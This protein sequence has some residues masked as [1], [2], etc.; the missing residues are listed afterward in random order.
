LQK[1]GGKEA[2]GR[3]WGGPA[4]S[5]SWHAVAPVG[6]EH[7]CL[8]CSPQSRV[9]VASLKAAPEFPPCPLGAGRPVALPAERPKAGTLPS[10]QPLSR[11]WA[12][13]VSENPECA[14]QWRREY[15]PLA[16]VG[17][18][19][20]GGTHLGPCMVVCGLMALCAMV[21]GSGQTRGW[22]PGSW[23]RPRAITS[24]DDF[25]ASPYPG[26]CS[27]QVCISAGCF[28]DELDFLLPRGMDSHAE[29]GLPLSP[30]E[31]WK[32]PT[33]YHPW[34]LGGPCG[35]AAAP[36]TLPTWGDSHAQSWHS[37][38]LSSRRWL[39]RTQEATNL[40]QLPWMVAPWLHLPPGVLCPGVPT[41]WLVVLSP[42]AFILNKPSLCPLQVGS[43]T[44]C[45]CSWGPDTGHS[46]PGNCPKLWPPTP[47]GHP[48][49]CPDLKTA[50]SW[51][52]SPLTCSLENPRCLFLLHLFTARNQ[53]TFSANF[54]CTW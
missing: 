42:L 20:A 6:C 47:P 5:Q 11:T 36:P 40:E 34:H 44:A 28:S 3:K 16:V 7:T 32:I 33:L 37:E 10:K 41:R 1:G 31:K 43:V 48:G 13:V 52:H 46:P 26:T 4:T 8:D 22:R 49:P 38:P 18:G 35:S 12:R 24:L 45:P 21:A 19:E 25:P 29:A 9:W 50:C 54:V 15:A 23:T 17:A 14:V 53:K 2:V 39:D 27:W 51:S 30:Q